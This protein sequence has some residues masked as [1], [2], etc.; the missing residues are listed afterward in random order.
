MKH[1]NIFISCAVVFGIIG[2]IGANTLLMPKILDSALAKETESVAQTAQASISTTIQQLNIQPQN[3]SSTVNEYFE[4][5][6]T[7][8]EFDAFISYFESKGIDAGWPGDLLSMAGK[9]MPGTYYAMEDV[10]DQLSNL[11]KE[12]EKQLVLLNDQYVYDGLRPKENMIWDTINK[13]KVYFDKDKFAV[14]F[15]QRELRDED[16]LQFLDFGY[17]LDYVLLHREG[18]VFVEDQM[19]QR[20]DVISQEEAEEKAKLLVEAVFGI[21]TE[22]KKIDFRYLF[23]QADLDRT[24]FP[25][26]PT[27]NVRISPYRKNTLAV[28]GVNYREY[29]VDWNLY[30]G[31]LISIRASDHD[32]DEISVHDKIGRI[33]LKKNAK[34]LQQ[35]ELLLSLAEKTAI[36]LANAQ[37]KSDAIKNVVVVDS[38][39]IMFENDLL[40]NSRDSDIAYGR[41]NVVVEMADGSAYCVSVYY[42]DY[43]IEHIYYNKST[44]AMWDGILHPVSRG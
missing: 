28:S 12:T 41:V 26:P 10:N 7:Q 25:D 19:K 8:E 18:A 13:D 34:E 31:D 42:A 6:M 14:Y 5:N 32:L 30:S 15:P 23:W 2:L 3:P 11:P 4:K 44:E 33:S 17:R 22:D 37:S 9:V 36:D 29:S 16:L 40:G 43:F 38:D 27:I 39:L 1:K 35:D 21:Q 20:T 24:I